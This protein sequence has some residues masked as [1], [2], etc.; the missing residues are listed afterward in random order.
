[1]TDRRIVIYPLTRGQD[2]VWHQAMS[3]FPNGMSHEIEVSF[4][5]FWLVELPDT[6]R[7]LLLLRLGDE[8]VLDLRNGWMLIERSAMREA[9]GALAGHRSTWLIG[10]VAC[11]RTHRAEHAWNAL[12]QFS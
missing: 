9:R 12:A 2:R 4:E 8:R 7:V 1:M 6:Y 3:E 11:F 10:R 5:R